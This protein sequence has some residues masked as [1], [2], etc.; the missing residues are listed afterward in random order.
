MI[1]TQQSIGKG[2]ETWLQTAHIPA[3]WF[4]F[5]H[6]AQSGKRQRCDVLHQ[7]T[8][9]AWLNF[10]FSLP[11]CDVTCD[12]HIVFLLVVTICS[13]LPFHNNEKKKI[14]FWIYTCFSQH[15]NRMCCKCWNVYDTENYRLHLQWLIHAVIALG[16]MQLNGPEQDDET[17]GSQ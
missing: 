1:L 8:V 4:H 7:Y 6:S 11:R 3:C 10:K 5:P 17:S 12:V 14:L 15:K 13:Y 9:L 16:S 2:G